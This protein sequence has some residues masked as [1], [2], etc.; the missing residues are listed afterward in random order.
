MESFERIGT[1]FDLKKFLGIE[2]SVLGLLEPTGGEGDLKSFA[3]CIVVNAVM[4]RILDSVV[5]AQ[6]VRFSGLLLA[7]LADKYPNNEDIKRSS[8]A[9]VGRLR[10]L[11][12]IYHCLQQKHGFTSEAIPDISYVIDHCIYQDLKSFR[13]ADKGLLEAVRGYSEKMLPKLFS[14]LTQHARGL[15]AC[16]GPVTE[17]VAE[18]ILEPLLGYQFTAEEN[19]AR[20]AAVLPALMDHWAVRRSFDRCKSLFE[21][22]ETMNLTTAQQT[23][24]R[25]FQLLRSVDD[26]VAS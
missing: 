9:S 22:G 25:I 1:K 5:R 12:A 18:R 24:G 15:L 23:L 3:K 21:R 2:R 8:N 13:K 19:R 20:A 10:D 4:S 14:E 16:S 26:S 11:H 7:F 17:V 6:L